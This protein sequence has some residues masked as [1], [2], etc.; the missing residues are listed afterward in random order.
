MTLAP[1]SD[2]RKKI[3]SDAMTS[4][5]LWMISA[6][7]VHHLTDGMENGSLHADRRVILV[8]IVGVVMSLMTTILLRIV[9]VLMIVGVTVIIALLMI[10]AATF[11]VIMIVIVV[12]AF[13][14][15]VFVRVMTGFLR[16][17]VLQIQSQILMSFRMGMSMLMIHC[18]RVFVLMFIFIHVFLVS[19]EALWVLLALIICIR[20][21][22][23][24]FHNRDV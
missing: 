2:P 22:Q 24:V 17:Q 4:P 16:M 23:G 8:L 5:T 18:M 10:V 7:L 13:L 14:V 20:V 9:I 15:I 11:L 6:A 21:V 1:L 12:V 19:G 3:T